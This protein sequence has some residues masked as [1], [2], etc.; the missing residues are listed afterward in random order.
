MRL[1]I[2]GL[3]ILLAVNILVD[4]YIAR[5]IRRRVRS[6]WPLRLHY[7]ACMTTFVLFVA[8]AAMPLTALPDGMFHL[9]SWLLLAF[10]ALLAPRYIFTFF[11][12][13]A[14][15][16]RLFGHRRLRV[17]SI[18]GAVL[19]LLSFVM[20]IWGT[21]ITRYS[22]QV[23]EVNVEIA[24]LPDDFDGYTIVQ[25]SDMH[26]GS[27]GNC[28]RFVRKLSDKIN[29]LDAD[30]VVFTG[31]IVNRHADE[32]R[33]F[34]PALSRVSGRDGQYAILGN[35]DYA[36]YYYPDDS[37]ARAND[38]ARLINF[39][40]LTAF[41]LI[42]DDY[43]T[44]Y[45]GNDSIILIGVENIGEPPFHAYGNLEMSYPDLSDSNTKIL[46]SHDPSHWHNDIA[47]HRDKNIA[48]T[49]SGH[50]HAMQTRILGWS[51]AS[52]MHPEWGG[53]Y[54]DDNGQHQLYVNIGTGTVGTPMR[55][56][57]TPEI[58]LITLRKPSTK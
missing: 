16:P 58:T 17:L 51:P 26:V 53:L 42:L 47:N 24:G 37:I 56:G 55:I 30:M 13:C 36:D 14:S 49:L 57:A 44:I 9:F 54:S 27:Y 45:R 19:A 8:I 38:R 2:A 1:N 33:P 32:I 10:F 52:L 46:L 43:R 48:L 21:F 31:D 12:L 18:A 40:S 3:M 20:I 28:D 5:A 11:D 22:M 15:V 6:R 50:T 35:H 39:Y 29:E 41:D 7:V 25:I 23:K 34:L 4:I